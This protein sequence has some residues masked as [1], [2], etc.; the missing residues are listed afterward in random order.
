M[1]SNQHAIETAR[2]LIE[3]TS[4]CV[5]SISGHWTQ[6]DFAHLG[7][8]TFISIDGSPVILTANHVIEQQEAPFRGFAYSNGNGKVAFFDGAETFFNEEADVA[9]KKIDPSTF[10]RDTVDEERIAESSHT[11]NGDLVFLHGYPGETSRQTRLLHSQGA[12]VN[13]SLPLLTKI[14]PEF[15]CQQSLALDYAIEGVFDETEEMS[16][17]PDPHGLSG[18]SLWRVPRNGNQWN[19]EEAKIIGLVKLWD[20]VSSC[21]YAT[22]IE[23]VNSLI[24]QYR[25]L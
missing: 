7:S 4:C 22:R 18:T 25:E 10:D 12:L 1:P 21:L 2:I 14:I 16:S 20:Q 11:N 23:I 19:P 17:L 3:M 8:G 9:I 24:D 13:E 6:G 15:C 5:T